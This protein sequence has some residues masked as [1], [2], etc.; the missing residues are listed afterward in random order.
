MKILEFGTVFI[1]PEGDTIIRGWT[2]DWEGK[3]V[4]WQ[5][6]ID[7]VLKEIGKIGGNRNWAANKFV[8][9]TSVVNIETAK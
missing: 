2:L 9:T 6:F 8:N 7:T 4:T 1:T 5:D 3:P